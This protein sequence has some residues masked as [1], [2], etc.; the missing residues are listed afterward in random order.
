M[1]TNVTVIIPIRNEERF[2]ARTLDALLSQDYSREFLEIQVIDGMSTDRTCEI[3]SQYCQRFP[4]IAWHKNP[5]CW[6]S[7]ARN[8]GIRESKGELIL[9]VDGHCE[10]TDRQYLN[11]LVAAFQRSGADCLGR[12][13]PLDVSHATPIQRAI[14][15]ARQSPL[16][17]HP[18][19]FI[20]STTE[21]PAPAKPA[22][23][24]I[25]P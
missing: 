19:S 14:A 22:A 23:K 24:V 21:R 16:G 10:L 4:Y 1:S 13:Q 5:N 6:S 7:S 11:K 18:D 15:A 17:H 9:I 3:V 25:S 20:Y 2:I 12:P 8:I